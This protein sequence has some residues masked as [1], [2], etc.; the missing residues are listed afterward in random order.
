[1]SDTYLCRIILITNKTIILTIWHTNRFS[2]QKNLVTFHAK[3]PPSGFKFTR[4]QSTPG[5]KIKNQN[6]HIKNWIILNN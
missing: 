2:F 3:I 6:N 4:K 1:M 5:S